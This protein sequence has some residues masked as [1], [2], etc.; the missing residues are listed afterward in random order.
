MGKTTGQA[1]CPTLH[2]E[3]ILADFATAL[4]D[5]ITDGHDSPTL[6]SSTLGVK[7]RYEE[8]SPSGCWSGYKHKYEYL[9]GQI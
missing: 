8:L 7:L 9:I 1:G 5:R 4:L 2:A 3:M 6:L